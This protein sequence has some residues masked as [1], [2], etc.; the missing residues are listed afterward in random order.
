MR[1]HAA[2]LYVSPRS[3]T[4]TPQEHETRNISYTLKDPRAYDFTHVVAIAAKE[5]ANLIFGTCTLIPIPNSRGGTEANRRL[6]NAIA[7]HIRGA[8]VKDV[9][10]RAKPVESSCSRH[11]ARL[12]PLPVDEHHI[13]RDPEKYLILDQI[14]F[15][16]NTTTSGNTLRAANRAIGTGDGLV[17]SDAGLPLFNK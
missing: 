2:R 6:A 8:T 14:Y 7:R 17:F 15:V 13:E 5:M 3:R 16:D 11:K 4:L 10:R 1:I 12:G 9:L